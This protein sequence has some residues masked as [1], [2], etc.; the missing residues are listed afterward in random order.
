MNVPPNLAK[1]LHP[2]H[3][4]AVQEGRM[5]V[6]KAQALSKVAAATADYSFKRPSLT[7][8]EALAQTDKILS[9]L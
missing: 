7:Q 3:L 9:G 8:E 4:L 1:T 5:S 6:R 2:I